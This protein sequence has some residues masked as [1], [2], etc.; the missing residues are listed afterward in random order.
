MHVL[1]NTDFKNSQNVLN[2]IMKAREYKEEE[3]REINQ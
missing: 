1:L 2:L 3:I